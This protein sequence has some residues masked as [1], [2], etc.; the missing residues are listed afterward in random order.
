MF[1][2]VSLCSGVPVQGAQVLRHSILIYVYYHLYPSAHQS[3]LMGALIFDQVP[4]PMPVNS[5]VGHISVPYL[6]IR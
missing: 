6:V 1:L 5:H 4:G 3:S 2:I